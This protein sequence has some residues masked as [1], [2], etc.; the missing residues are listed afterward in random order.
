MQDQPN[1]ENFGPNFKVYLAE[2]DPESYAEAMAS[3]DAPFWRE[4]IDDE[5]H[6]IMSNNTWI[7][8]DLP[9]GC[10]SIDCRW[11]FRKKLKSD[12]TLDKYKDHLVAKGFIQF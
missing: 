8:S 12:G 11:I 2:R 7:L 3:H 10:K 5:M 1:Q 6:S 9:P 4:A